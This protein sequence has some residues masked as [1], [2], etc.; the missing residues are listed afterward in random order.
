MT[1]KEQCSN[2]KFSKE[3]ATYYMNG[4]D[5]YQICRLTPME[6]RKQ[7]EDWCGM[8]KA[9]IDHEAIACTKMFLERTR[10]DRIIL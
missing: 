4:T 10:G 7:N 9:K 5:R 1:E 2:C 8:W 3:G 6:R